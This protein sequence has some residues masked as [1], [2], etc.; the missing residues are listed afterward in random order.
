MAGQPNAADFLPFLEL[1]DPRGIRMEMLR[2]YNGLHKLFDGII[3][4]RIDR[5]ADG[6]DRLG[7]FLNISLDHVDKP[8]PDQLTYDDVKILLPVR[9]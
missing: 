1:F 7:D 4:K 8:S 9:T 2:C 6:S 5:R 3:T